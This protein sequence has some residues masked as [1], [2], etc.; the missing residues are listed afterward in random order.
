MSGT[1]VR[2]PSRRR[3]L[4][5]GDVS[6]GLT[7]DHRLQTLDR[8]GQ[9]TTV[10]DIRPYAIHNPIGARLLYRFPV[11]PLIRRIN[12]DLLRAVHQ[13]KPDVVWFDKPTQFTPATLTGIRQAGALAVCYN[14]DNPFG[15]RKDR[16]WYQFKKAFRHFDLHCVPRTVD[17]AR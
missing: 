17:V 2:L 11:E 9:E 5:V 15:P 10:F 14:L 1:S 12:R 7:A 4:Y 16:C 6:P 13:H 8:L 3:I